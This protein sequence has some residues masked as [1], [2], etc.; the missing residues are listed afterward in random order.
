MNDGFKCRAPWKKNTA[1]VQFF[2]HHIRQCIG[3]AQRLRGGRQPAG[4]RFYI[5]RHEGPH[6]HPVE[7]QNEMLATDL[8]ALEITID[9]AVIDADLPRQKP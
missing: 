7:K 5:S 3:L 8:R 4:E 9:I 1:T 6:P 2:Y